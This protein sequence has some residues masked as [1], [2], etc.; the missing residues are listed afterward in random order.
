[1]SMR[2]SYLIYLAGREA[3]RDFAAGGALPKIAGVLAQ[4]APAC[5]RGSILLA[6]TWLPACGRA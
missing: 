2:R 1:M 5:L 6:A 3:K 4:P